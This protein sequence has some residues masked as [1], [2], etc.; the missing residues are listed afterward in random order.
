[1]SRSTVVPGWLR[2]FV[3]VNPI[4]HLV[5]AERCLIGGTAT[6]AEIIWVLVASAALAAVFAPL[7]MWIYRNK[8]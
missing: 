3:E 7:T 2:S 6:A 8:Q 1:V 5:T 4:T